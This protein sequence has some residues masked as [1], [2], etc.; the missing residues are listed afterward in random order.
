M[1]A[2]DSGGDMRVLLGQQ[3]GWLAVCCCKAVVVAWVV[4]GEL[5]AVL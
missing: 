5:G 1:P 3:M 2:A 4:A